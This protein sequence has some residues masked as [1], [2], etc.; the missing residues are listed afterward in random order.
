MLPWTRT[1][2]DQIAGRAQ[3]SACALATQLEKYRRLAAHRFFLEIPKHILCS[4]R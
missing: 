4:E 3:I 1:T 2:F